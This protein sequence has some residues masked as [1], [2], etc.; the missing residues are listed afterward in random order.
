MNTK[1]IRSIVLAATLLVGG[2]AILSAAESPKEDASMVT[3]LVTTIVK[4]DYEGFVSNGDAPFKQ[5][6]KDQ[7][8]AASSQL[9]PKLKA[10]HEI[11][12]LGEL[13][14]NGYRVT[15][16]K[17]SFKD[18]SDDALATLS[19]KDGKVGGFYIR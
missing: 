17:V 6:T 15:L 19:M 11:S 4:S 18:G 13:K 14:Q 3:K 12:Y 7:F 8:A 9:A 10:G 16:W 5:I 2:S 1:S